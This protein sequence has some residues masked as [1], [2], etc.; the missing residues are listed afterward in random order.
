MVDDILAEIGNTV[1]PVLLDAASA[2]LQ[3]LDKE[4]GTKICTISLHWA[5]IVSKDYHMELV[6]VQRMVKTIHDTLEGLE[7]FYT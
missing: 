5:R 4:E 6:V 2:F 3:I 7:G 1:I